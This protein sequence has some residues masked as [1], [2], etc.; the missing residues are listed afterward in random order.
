VQS[1]VTPPVTRGRGRGLAV[2]FFTL[3][4]MVTVIAGG[5][6]HGK[7]GGVFR[8]VGL[9]GVGGFPLSLF[10]AIVGAPGRLGNWRTWLAVVV[11]YY[12]AWSFVFECVV[13]SGRRASSR[14]L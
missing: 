7:E 12:V 6:G 9:V 11:V 14:A 10:T 3:A 5:L 1:D 2:L 13:G 8:A 4:M